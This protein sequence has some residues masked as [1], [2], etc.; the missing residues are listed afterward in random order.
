[1]RSDTPLIRNIAIVVFIGAMALAAALLQQKEIV[2]PEV[3]ALCVG[4]WLMPKAVWNARIRQIP[5]LLTGAALIGL[6]VNALVPWGFEA[7]F[8]I[9]FIAV[10]AMLRLMRCNMYPVVSAAMLPVLIGTDSWVYPAAVL[11]LSSLLSLGR[12]WFHQTDRPGYRSDTV[13]HWLWLTIALVFV[14]FATWMVK[15]YLPEPWSTS[16]RFSL[17]PPLVVTMIEFASRKSGFRQRPWTIWGLIVAAAII[18]TSMELLFHRHMGI[19]ALGTMISTAL[20]LLLFRWFKPFAPALAISLV[21]LL[22]PDAVLPYFPVMAAVGSAY[23]IIIGMICFSER[24]ESLSL[25]EKKE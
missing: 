9:A 15:R 14:L 18:G 1:M 25:S 23:F 13:F 10:V 2:F 17:V 12:L 11:V 3:G 16:I 20:M 21:P 19:P 8:V 5:L 4:L 22:L 24:K 7:K 6:F